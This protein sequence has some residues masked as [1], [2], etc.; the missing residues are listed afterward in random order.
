MF[1]TDETGRTIGQPNDSATELAERL[2]GELVQLQ[3]SSARIAVPCGP[4][5]LRRS[6][7][8]VFRSIYKVA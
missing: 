2:G 3:Q 1:W 6:G 4:D 8:W 5:C 7:C